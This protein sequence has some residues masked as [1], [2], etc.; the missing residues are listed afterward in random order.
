VLRDFAEELRRSLEDEMLPDE[1]R[2][3]LLVHIAGYV[4]CDNDDCHPEFWFVNNISGIDDD[5][6]DYLGIGDKFTT[7]EDYWIRDYDKYNLEEVLKLGGYH[8]Y[9]NGFPSARIAYLGLIK[10]MKQFF[11]ELW[12]E[13]AWSFRPPHS[14]DETKLF[15]EMFLRVITTM[16]AVSDYRV[17]YVG[18]A[19]QVHSI[20]NP[21]Y[22]NNV[23]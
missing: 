20:P 1:K 6:G 11:E 3:G 9:I 4:N 21:V 13:P 15:V 7:S 14:L 5:T 19:P 2:D 16:F 10:N 18:G 22:E 8:L 17:Q 12:S 23:T